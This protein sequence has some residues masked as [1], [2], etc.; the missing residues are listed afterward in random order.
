LNGIFQ[1]LKILDGKGFCRKLIYPE[2]NWLGCVDAIGADYCI[3]KRP[4]FTKLKRV[5][6]G[7]CKLVAGEWYI[8]W[9]KI[10]ADKNEQGYWIKRR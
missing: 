1:W 3:V 7:L 10:A 5:G 4:W 9:L 2:G 6:D 8:G